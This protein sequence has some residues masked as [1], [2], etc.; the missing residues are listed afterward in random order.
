[1][2]RPA[3]EWFVKGVYTLETTRPAERASKVGTRD[4]LEFVAASHVPF[5]AP[6]AID[7][8]SF[9]ESAH[10]MVF[11]VNLTVSEGEF[12]KLAASTI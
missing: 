11:R 5:D 7:S 8:R 6:A 12:E 10:Q 9:L 3:G 1:L 2:E 4:A